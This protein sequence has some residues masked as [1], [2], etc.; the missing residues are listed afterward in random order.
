MTATCLESSIVAFTDKDYP[1]EDYDDYPSAF[2]DLENEN[3][4]PISKFPIFRKDT[5]TAREAY[6][7][8]RPATLLI[9]RIILQCW[10]TFGLFVRRESPG[11]SDVFLGADAELK[12]PKDEVIACIKSVLPDIDFD[13]DMSVN[14]SSFAETRLLPDS[15]TDLIVLDYN[16]VRLL[17]STS[18][19]SQKLSGLLYLAV[20]IGHELAHTLEFRSIRKG[21][22]VSGDKPFGTPPG[23]TGRE[24]GTA[25][26]TRA[27]GGKIFPVC[28]VE[29]VL[30]DIRGLCIRSSSWNFDMMKANGAWIRQLFKE[31]HWVTE[32]RPLQPPIDTYA[33]CSIFEDE[34][35]SV[36]STPM[37]PKRHEKDVV[38]QS[39]HPK[40]KRILCVPMSTCGG[41]K[42]G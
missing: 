27:F 31:Q 19:H 10:E 7:L 24:A 23:V 2:C 34:L 11:S 35:I 25:W 8:I 29:N 42:V 14:A 6:D 40:R 21:K 38:L 39:C 33:L 20:L 36:P 41:K 18:S 30:R 32:Q 1:C 9:S 17:K 22:L 26:E 16:L 3:L 12:L 15:K 4:F 37:K 28:E 5:S 13:P